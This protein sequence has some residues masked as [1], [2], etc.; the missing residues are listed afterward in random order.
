MMSRSINQMHSFGALCSQFCSFLYT[1]VPGTR[2]I[3]YL[4][5]R[6]NHL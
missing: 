1:L 2:K 4:D 6:L 5:P 3:R